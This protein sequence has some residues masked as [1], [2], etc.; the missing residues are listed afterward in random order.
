[1][2]TITKTSQSKEHFIEECERIYLSHKGPL[3]VFKLQNNCKAFL[4][5]KKANFK[6][7]TF[8]I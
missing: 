7:V 5:K 8:E 3:F 1:M 2:K 4:I 6:C